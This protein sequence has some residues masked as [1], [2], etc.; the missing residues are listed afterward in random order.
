MGQTTLMKSVC[1]GAIVLLMGTELGAES[2]QQWLTHQ[3][4]TEISIEFNPFGNFVDKEKM[5]QNLDPSSPRQIAGRGTAIKLTRPSGG[6]IGSLQ[7]R[8]QPSAQLQYPLSVAL[9]YTE[10]LS[11]DLDNDGNLSRDIRIRNE[12][13]HDTFHINDQF[14]RTDIPWVLPRFFYY[15]IAK[16]EV[17]LS[18][19]LEI[20]DNEGK[21]ISRYLC[22]DRISTDQT[23]TAIGWVMNESEAD[24]FLRE[25]AGIRNIQTIES[26]PSYINPFSE[27][28]ALWIAEDYW[29]QSPLTTQYLQ[30]LLLMGVWLYG[31]QATV[32]SI[33][34]S[35]G[36]TTPYSVLLGGIGAPNELSL[37]S[38]W[39]YS[40]GHNWRSFI[41]NDGYYNPED[42]RALLSKEH[43]FQPYRRFYITWTWSWL[44][45][46]SL[47][48][49]IGTPIAFNVL[50]G[51]K[52]LHLWWAL[53][54]ISLLTAVMGW[55]IGN[56]YLPRKPIVEVTEFRFAHASWP[57]VFVQDVIRIL[58]FNK[59]E[60]DLS[61]PENAFSLPS[62][63][64]RGIRR[65]TN[66]KTDYYYSDHQKSRFRWMSLSRGDVSE[67]EIAYFKKADYPFTLDRENSRLNLRAHQDFSRVVVWDNTQWH[68]LGRLN[69]GDVVDPFSGRKSRQIYGMPLTLTSLF[70]YGK[71]NLLAENI[72]YSH[73]Q[74]S[75]LRSRLDHAATLEN[76]I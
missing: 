51:D 29:E 34:E 67:R 12:Y 59:E 70:K 14:S 16:G 36:L 35:L 39:S 4:S 60:V 33:A 69:E 37:Q 65:K 56:A 23:D 18:C 52:R 74:N 42:D 10:V 24:R 53:P 27:I 66:T 13:Y 11:E 61:V 20:K 49:L 45:S 63:N 47:I 48:L 1:V 19:R 76:R 26:V 30:R 7:L 64:W 8:L 58:S 15:R 62:I 55:G 2:Y 68:H 73:G 43:I 9:I 6:Y 40:S 17:Y 57:E 44:I 31:R 50:K 71:E 72:P 38:L 25:N 41:Q 75:S 21:M 46:F 3:P 32:D 22:I 54:V 28:A 5:A